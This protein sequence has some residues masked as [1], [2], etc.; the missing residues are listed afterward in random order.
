MP[1]ITRTMIKMAMVYALAGT[2]LSALWLV[3][4]AWPMHPVLRLVQPT[5]LHLIVMGWL[6]QLI[7]GIALWMFPP[8]SKEQPRGPIRPTWLCFGLLNAGLLLRL[9]AEPL[10]R[11]A[12]APLLA[13]LLVISAWLQ[14]GAIILFVGLTWSRV[15]VKGSVR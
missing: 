11:Y 9:I 6:T 12:P 14:V 15:R 8:W 5:A 3:E 4:I 13:W 7:F 1:L 10:N 2:A